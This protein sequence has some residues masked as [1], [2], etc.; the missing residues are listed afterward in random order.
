[1]IRLI[2]DLP[3]GSTVAASREVPDC[4]CIMNQGQVHYH[5]ELTGPK[6]VGADL[7]STV[8]Q[9]AENLGAKANFK[10][11]SKSESS[12]HPPVKCPSCGFASPPGSTLPET[13]AVVARAAPVSE[14]AKSDSYPARA[15]LLPLPAPL[16]LSLSVRVVF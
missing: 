9:L 4:Q 6:L 12:R 5:A 15:D 8:A 14:G 2:V 11:V 7:V 16:C 13:F 10:F 1:M 3:E